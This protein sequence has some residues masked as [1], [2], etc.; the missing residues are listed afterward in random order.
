MTVEDLT[1]DLAQQFGYKESKGVVIT[2]VDTG[3]DAWRN[4]LQ[5]GQ[6]ITAVNRVSVS[7]GK[8]F[9]GEVAKASKAKAKSILL[10]VKAGE[11]ARFVLL[12]L[13]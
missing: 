10:M 3:S 8:E 9:W 1:S 5:P 2:Q 13:E 6:L 11:G 4:G 7:D 12:K